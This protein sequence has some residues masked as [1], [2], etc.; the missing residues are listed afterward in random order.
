MFGLA[1][2][3]D[4]SQ[5]ER[6]LE[7]LEDAADRDGVVA[8]GVLLDR[9]RGIPGQPFAIIV[10]RDTS[11]GDVWTGEENNPMRKMFLTVIDVQNT[12][13]AIDSITFEWP[14]DRLGHLGAFAVSGQV[15]PEPSTLL[16]LCIGGVGLLACAWRKRRRQ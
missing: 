4:L 3:P 11:G 16:L 14:A 13:D 12:N 15:V 5:G 10:D 9:R 8:V 6:E 7:R 1:L 2:T